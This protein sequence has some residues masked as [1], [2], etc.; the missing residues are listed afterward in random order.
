MIANRRG[1]LALYLG[2]CLVLIVAMGGAIWYLKQARQ[3]GAVSLL[4]KLKADYQMES[5]ITMVMQKI[6]IQPG[7]GDATASAPDALDLKSQ[8]IAPGLVLSLMH[9]RLAPDQVRFEA[10]VEGNGFARRLAAQAT[11]EFLPA[12]G[13]A[14][15]VPEIAASGDPRWYLEFL[16]DDGV[17]GGR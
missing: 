16:P 4:L 1:I 9:H 13:P 6:R 17:G 8:E 11:R 15:S 2:L 3:A 14:S 10:R 12:P 7:R 5:A